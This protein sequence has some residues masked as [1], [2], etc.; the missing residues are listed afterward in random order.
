MILFFFVKHTYKSFNHP[1]KE[2]REFNGI[3]LHPYPSSS[4]RFP[5]RSWLT[6]TYVYS[7]GKKVCLEQ[8][9]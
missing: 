9:P 5:I 8:D 1:A 4:T 7:I 6:F 2:L 3:K